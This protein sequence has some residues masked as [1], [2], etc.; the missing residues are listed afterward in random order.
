MNF[1][2]FG[3]EN[4]NALIQL[5]FTKH[6]VE[7]VAYSFYFNHGARLLLRSLGAE[8]QSDAHCALS[9]SVFITTCVFPEASVL[10]VSTSP[11][12]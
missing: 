3:I 4:Y 1:I 2:L 9:V 12:I 10:M 11:E 7:A 8:H 6:V 5:N